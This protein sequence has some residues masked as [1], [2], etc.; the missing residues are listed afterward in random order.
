MSNQFPQPTTRSINLVRVHVIC[1][2]TCVATFQLFMVLFHPNKFKST[3][4]IQCRLCHMTSAL[5]LT[6]AVVRRAILLKIFQVNSSLSFY[7]VNK[8]KRLYMHVFP[9]STAMVLSHT[10]FDIQTR[11]IL[12]VIQHFI[13]NQLINL[14]LS[15]LPLGSIKPS[16]SIMKSA[17]LDNIPNNPIPVVY[18]TTR[19]HCSKPWSILSFL[20]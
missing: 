16:L 20:C 7:I 15:K 10:F 19:R 4:F 14:S 3:S 5:Q 6:L 2:C 11:A 17:G 1:P 12:C 13:L 18:V 8:V 9:A